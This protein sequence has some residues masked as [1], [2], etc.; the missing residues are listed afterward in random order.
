MVVL[1]VVCTIA[2]G[3]YVQANLSLKPANAEVENEPVLPNPQL[4]VINLSP[5][6]ESLKWGTVDESL[7]TV[8]EVR[9]A[10]YELLLRNE[11]FLFKPGWLHREIATFSLSKEKTEQ[12]DPINEHEAA[13]KNMFT[14]NQF[15]SKW[16]EILDEKGTM[17]YGIYWVNRDD[18]GMELQVLAV[19]EQGRGGNLT[20][21]RNGTS[22]LFANPPEVE[23]QL[24]QLQFNFQLRSSTGKFLSD[25]VTM[26]PA[27]TSIKAWQESVNDQAVFH[28]IVETAAKTPYNYQYY[29]DPITNFIME[30]TFTMENG[31]LQTMKDFLV[32]DKDDMVL[33]GSEEYLVVETLAAMPPE[34]EKAYLSAVQEA[35]FLEGEQK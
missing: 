28:V 25:L 15:T 27:I 30:Y 18:A 32:S 6:E 10:M 33:N 23:T 2:I 16:T 22:E 34:V 3:V 29:P 4:Q 7:T 5:Q 21:L 8:D 26:Q 1:L 14:A 17:G 20:M 9:A 13:I 19:D 24:S 11:A 31:Q 12:M 35:I